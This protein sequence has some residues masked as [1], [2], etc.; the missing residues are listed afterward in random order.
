M[1]WLW[2]AAAVL[3]EA[4]SHSSEHETKGTLCDIKCLSGQINNLLNAMLPW[5]CKV[6]C[7]HLMPI[8][9]IINARTRDSASHTHPLP[10]CLCTYAGLC[11]KDAWGRLYH[12]DVPS[13]VTTALSFSPGAAVLLSLFRHTEVWIINE[14]ITS[15]LLSPTT[16]FTRGMC[17]AEH[18]WSKSWSKD[19]I[20]SLFNI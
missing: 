13:L 4:L 9:H 17:R 8:T 6:E 12:C 20:S 5:F 3:K 15:I 14:F 1:L 10:P 16:V 19:G 7:G 2:T 11:M 18:R